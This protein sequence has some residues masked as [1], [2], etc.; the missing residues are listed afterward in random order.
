[1]EAVVHICFAVLR[2]A[3]NRDAIQPM[4]HYLVLLAL[5]VIRFCINVPHT[6]LA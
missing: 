2:E 5:Q 4:W 1:M 6:S 3:M